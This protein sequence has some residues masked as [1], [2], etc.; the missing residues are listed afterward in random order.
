MNQPTAPLAAPLPLAAPGPRIELPD[1]APKALGGVYAEY[2]HHVTE[3]DRIADER[4][5][6]WADVAGKPGEYDVARAG[7]AL[8]AGEDPPRPVTT[9]LAEMDEQVAVHHAAAAQARAEL[10]EQTRAVADEELDRANTRRNDAHT[11]WV[12]AVDELADAHTELATSNAVVRFWQAMVNGDQHFSF[13]FESAPF[14]LT[15]VDSYGG[16]T[17][18]VQLFHDLKAAADWVRTGE[19]RD[20]KTGASR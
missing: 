19:D 15:G 12:A 5:R 8:R 20:A 4:R 2:L 16:A 6:L 11:R 17:R 14:A 9:R 3:A 1:D 18:A 10:L 7:E 13:A